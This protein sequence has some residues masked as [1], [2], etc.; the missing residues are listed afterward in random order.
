MKSYVS[1][2]NSLS[3]LVLWIILL[4][5]L[6]SG[7]VILSQIKKYDTIL[8]NQTGHKIIHL[9]YAQN[10]VDVKNI[11]LKWKEKGIISAAHNSILWD[12]GL[13][14]SYVLFLTSAYMLLKKSSAIFPVWTALGP[15]LI[16]G[17]DLLENIGLLTYLANPDHISPISIHLTTYLASLKLI[18]FISFCGIILIRFFS[19]P[20]KPAKE[21]HSLEEIIPEEQK[22]IE[23]KRNSMGY[24]PI[25][26]PSEG[27]FG[28]ALSG[29]GIRSATINLGI[30]DILNRIGLLTRADYLSTVSGGGFLGSFVHAKLREMASKEKVASIFSE[31]EISH[32][33]EHGD[34]LTPGNRPLTIIKALGAFAGSL[35][36]NWSWAL[37]FLLTIMYALGT[38]VSILV[39]LPEVKTFLLLATI[40]ILFS[41]LFLYSLRTVTIGKVRLW[42]TDIIYAI[43]GILLGLWLSIG[44]Y[45][46]SNNISLFQMIQDTGFYLPGILEELPPL[47][48]NFILAI[49]LLLISGFFFNPNIH[50]MHRF[51]RDRIAD[52]YLAA[53]G[54]EAKN[55]KLHELTLDKNRNPR[56]WNAPYPLINACLNLTGEKDEA[57][58]GAR[59]S[60]YFLFSPLFCGSK[61]TNYLPTKCA[62]YHN[63]TLATATAISGAAVNPT[64]G[65]YTR[66]ALSFLMSLL[67]LKL[68]YWAP[69]PKFEVVRKGIEWWPLYLFS[70]LFSKT[71][72]RKG[73]VNLSD[74][75]H[76]E[77]L[78]VYELLRRKCKLIIAIDAGAD[79]EFTFEDLEN[80]VI[81]SRNELG[82]AI[83]FLHKPEERIFPHPSLGFSQYHYV[84]ADLIELPDDEHK[85]TPFGTLVYIKSSIKAPQRKWKKEEIAQ[86]P[87][88]RSFFYKTYHPAFPQESTADQYFDEAQWTAY[89]HLGCFMAGDLFNIDVREESTLNEMN[90]SD[91]TIEELIQL[92]KHQN[93]P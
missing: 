58:Q 87:W 33:R 51:Y 66:P 30:L 83:K 71:D 86:H 38:G 48:S 79:P 28:I 11:V 50:S 6:A 53:A 1:F 85:S 49:I 76:I 36:L 37:A 29:G 25:N 40:I 12:W 14:I 22:I 74:G 24:P 5:S 3:P 34:Y 90:F 7:I 69:N 55:L 52:A 93:T 43:E 63:I 42:S 26:H 82:I 54:K 10:N 68:G 59:S 47:V 23:K 21:F 65:Y 72:T 75:G 45:H 81:R 57:F 8:Q 61:Q 15:L 67:G 17:L 31:K 18:L 91:K 2:L 62:G 35:V 88:Y 32:F 92:W 89:Y 70:E 9:Q 16:G 60:D 19:R 73:R 80:L 39:K 27:F 77:N 13:I 46:L 78:G 56:E 4:L 41:H 20:L 44:F 64:M 84:V